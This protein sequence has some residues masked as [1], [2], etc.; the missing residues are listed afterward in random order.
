VDDRVEAVRCEWEPSGARRHCPRTVGDALKERSPHG[1]PEPFLRK[2][3]E[4]DGGSRDLRDVQTGPAL[5]RAQIEQSIAFVQAQ[6]LNE[7]VRLGRRR[8]AGWL[9]SL[10]RSRHARACAGHRLVRDR[11]APG[12]TRPLPVHPCFLA[13]QPPFTSFSRLRATRRDHRPLVL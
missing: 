11:S 10:L 6:S 9:R 8:V 5:P 1:G 2:I 12:T 13:S 7:Q 3:R 4:H